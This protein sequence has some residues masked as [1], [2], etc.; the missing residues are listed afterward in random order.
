MKT[1]KVWIM[2]IG[3]ICFPGTAA[4][5]DCI[6]GSD[7]TVYSYGGASQWNFETGRWTCTNSANGQTVSGE[8][9]DCQR[10]GGPDAGVDDDLLEPLVGDRK[11]RKGP[12]KPGDPRKRHEVPK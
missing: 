11:P 3:L 9:T 2:T 6:Q 8:R 7:G 5:T 10:G 12:I 4:W 1:W